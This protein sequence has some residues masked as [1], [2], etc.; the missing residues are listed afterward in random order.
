MAWVRIHDAALSHPKVI[1]LSDKAFRLWVWGLSHSQ[2]HLTDG[3]IE[4]H[5]VPIRLRRASADLVTN[6]LWEAHDRGFSVHDYLDWNDSR[7]TVMKKRNALQQRVTDFRVKRAMTSGVGKSTDL[8][9]RESEG[10]PPNGASDE[11]LRARAGRLREELYPAW[12]SK[13]RNGAQLALIASPIEFQ[14]ALTLVKTW[15]DERLEKLARIV[16][17]TDADEWIT[18]TDRG[19][20]VFFKKAS[21]ADD[22]LRQA[23]QGT[24]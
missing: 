10:K 6:R 23:E 4:S 9:E 20:H 24:L 18:R 17:T 21:W 5:T 1:G 22:R 8:S 14:Q 12:Y 19:F 11:R 13:W 2:Q 3:L 7:E 15:P 16:L